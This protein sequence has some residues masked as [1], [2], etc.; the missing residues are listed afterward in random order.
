MGDMGDVT[1][2]RQDVS[3]TTEM[4]GEEEEIGRQLGIVHAPRDE[5]AALSHV[6]GQRGAKDLSVSTAENPSDIPSVPVRQYVAPKSGMR[7]ATGASD[8][9]ARHITRMARHLQITSDRPGELLCQDTFSVEP[10][11]GVAGV[12]VHVVVD[13]HDGHAFGLLSAA[14]QRDAAVAVLDRDVLPFYR[15]R[16]LPVGAVLTDN[17]RAFCGADGHPY[18]RYL[19]LNGIERR[20]MR[21]SRPLAVG[22]MERFI[23][24][25]LKSFFHNA[26]RVPFHTSVDALQVDLDIWLANYNTTR[27]HPVHP[28]NRRRLG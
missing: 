28:N 6:N 14:S 10:V 27:S 24:L 22:V 16:G 25:V 1:M 3:E 11:T 2:A 12:A 17:R 13:V 21:V 19:T 20:I 8:P 4:A 23:H 5:D 26:I 15:D 9:P 18:P 7:A